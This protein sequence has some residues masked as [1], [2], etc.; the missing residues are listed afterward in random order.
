MTA[1]RS[2][3]AA[4]LAAAALLLAA[5]A[6]AGCAARAQKV[7]TALEPPAALLAA[8]DVAVAARTNLTAGVPVSGTL[9][10]AIDVKVTAA[11][12]EVLAAVPVRE[13][14]RVVKGQ[15]LA[16]FRA[17]T[18][19]PAAASAKAALDLAR[20]DVE[21]YRD[22]LKA[23]AVSQRDVDAAEAQW[24]VAAANEAQ[25]RRTL[26]DASVRASVRPAIA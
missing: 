26:D 13:G 21:R 20:A 22:L 12:D 16:R 9:D 24:R 14:Q 10:P 7:A 11:F 3:R 4:R 5:I 1:P 18:M 2:T 19:A 25:A 8:A 17:E 23:G 6:A 15:V